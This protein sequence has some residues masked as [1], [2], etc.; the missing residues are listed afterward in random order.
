MF[1]LDIRRT[2]LA[3]LISRKENRPA[4]FFREPPEH[5]LLRGTLSRRRLPVQISWHANQH[6]GR[7]CQRFFGT[8]DDRVQRPC[9][10]GEHVQPWYPWICL[11]YTSDAADER[12]S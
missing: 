9:A 7:A 1:R 10:A 2:K 8:R 12:S 5:R 4:C 11:L 6:D 3:G